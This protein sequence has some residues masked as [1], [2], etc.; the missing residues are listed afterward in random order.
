MLTS[1]LVRHTDRG[2]TS[3]LHSEIGQGQITVFDDGSLEDTSSRQI[4]CSGGCQKQVVELDRKAGETI[5]GGLGM[6][7]HGAVLLR[8]CR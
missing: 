1:V 7:R 2:P 4:G 5:E 8:D 3:V 6:L